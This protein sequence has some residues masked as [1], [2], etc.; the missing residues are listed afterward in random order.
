MDKLKKFEIDC[1]TF[2]KK[3]KIK[4][5]LLCGNK[6]AINSHS[7]SK[8]FLNEIAGDKTVYAS[9]RGENFQSFSFQK[10]HINKA[11]TRT[12][13]CSKCDNT[14]FE[15]LDNESFNINEQ[16][17]FLLAF[18]SISSQLH[19]CKE[20]LKLMVNLKDV[21]NNIGENTLN[22]QQTKVYDAQKVFDFMKQNLLLRN[23]SS[24]K[25]NII[26]LDFACNFIYSG[27]F[28][29]IYDILGKNIHN[30]NENL[31]PLFLNIFIQNGKTYIIISWQDDKKSK[32]YEKWFAQVNNMSINDKLNY[33][34]KLAI[35][36]SED[37]YFSPQK[38]E[39]Y[40]VDIKELLGK[41]IKTNYCYEISDIYEFLNCN[42]VFNIFTD[43]FDDRLK[44]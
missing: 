37:I 42:I 11:S 44:Y 18:R 41:F 39:N 20:V 25:N 22:M 34:S 38:Y 14:I 2:G 10:L 35:F 17:M 12:N 13:F 43:E 33:L 36:N 24:I 6:T 28:P 1:N 26:I 3:A 15:T 7:I 4:N 8:C 16:K 30:N 32:I 5:C 9:F 31:S 27:C 19:T 21:G 23:Y 40:A 29:V